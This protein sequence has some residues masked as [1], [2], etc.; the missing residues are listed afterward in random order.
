MFCPNCGEKIPS[1]SQ[2][3]PECGVGLAAKPK[4]S[5]EPE[6]EPKS[7]AKPKPE[8]SDGPGKKKIPS[9]KD[10]KLTRGKT[11]LA[12]TA[13]IVAIIAIVAVVS[14]ASARPQLTDEQIRQSFGG[15]GT[16]SVPIG[17]L[18]ETSD[19]C[20]LTSVR[21]ANSRDSTENKSVH[22][23]VKVTATYEGALA[24]ATCTYLSVFILKDGAWE[25]ESCTQTGYET[26]PIA[27]IPDDLLTSSTSSMMKEVD[28]SHPYKDADGHAQK[29]QELYANGF[30]CSVT[31]NETAQGAGSSVK[32]A[33]SAQKGIRSYSGTLTATFGW[34]ASGWT[35]TDCTV[36][37]GA[38]GSNL[39]SFVG[40]WTGELLEAK[41]SSA[42]L[43]YGG[44]ANPPVLT[45]KSV[46]PSAQTA[47][48][49]LT[50]TVH[51]H[52]CDQASIE[53]ST[54]D[55]QVTQS[56]LLLNIKE[57]SSAYQIFDGRNPI[58]QTVKFQVT[59]DGLVKLYV[60]SAGGLGVW[61]S[62]TY[63]L[64]KTAEATA[65]A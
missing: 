40:T 60:E 17:A 32:M 43:C 24:K 18:W 62:D 19:E 33:I 12:I 9:S 47:V 10:R 48:V 58:H 15:D 41:R 8:P 44:R 2:F 31:Q 49:D 64:N 3:C 51:P 11:V 35:L 56:N 7:E 6:H 54:E 34:D 28:S 38:Y 25:F 52:T 21:T 37:E 45:V 65:A 14:T 1:Q 50:Y 29:L 42:F 22:R 20:K 4:P 26:E 23:S 57:N 63:K 59:S 39:N 46:D 55:V 13:A 27:A 16:V 5:P 53:S 36:D 61:Q 30:N